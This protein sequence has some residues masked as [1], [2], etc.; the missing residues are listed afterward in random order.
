VLAAY[1][2]RRDGEY[3]NEVMLSCPGVA[4]GVLPA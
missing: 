1:R 2:I 3:D 4:D